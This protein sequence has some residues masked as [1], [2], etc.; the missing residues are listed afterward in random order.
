MRLFI[1]FEGK[2][3][4]H[5]E[6][7]SH[8]LYVDTK[9]M[10]T[11]F[12]FLVHVKRKYALREHYYLNLTLDHFFIADNESIKVLHDSDKL[13][14]RI[15]KMNVTPKCLRKNENIDSAEM[16]TVESCVTQAES[17][18]DGTVEAVSK[19]K[20]TDVHMSDENSE[21]K[22]KETRKSSPLKHKILQSAVCKKPVSMQ[23]AK[24][25]VDLF[26]PRKFQLKP[27]TPRAKINLGSLAVSSSSLNSRK[28]RI[29]NS[30]AYQDS[31]HSYKKNVDIEKS[32][33]SKYGFRSLD[34]QNQRFVKAVE[35]DDL[36][37]TDDAT[38]KT[39][40]KPAIQKTRQV[41][42]GH[43]K[44]DSESDENDEVMQTSSIV[45]YSPIVKP[46]YVEPPPLENSKFMEPSEGRGGLASLKSSSV[47]ANERRG[48]MV[49]KI[50]DAYNKK[51][52]SILEE[53][54]TQGSGSESDDE[55][56]DESTSSEDEALPKN[57]KNVGRFRRPDKSDAPMKNLEDASKKPDSKTQTPKDSDEGTNT[58]LVSEP[59][60]S[61][62]TTSIPN[63]QSSGP[64]KSALMGC[65]IKPTPGL[66]I[67]SVVSQL[68]RELEDS[69]DGSVENQKELQE[70]NVGVTEKK[71]IGDREVEVKAIEG[72][73]NIGDRGQNNSA[74]P[75]ESLENLLR[76]SS[77]HIAKNQAQQ[78]SLIGN[79]SDQIPNPT[80][81]PESRN[82]RKADA[83]SDTQHHAKA[84]PN[85]SVNE[86]TSEDGRKKQRF[87]ISDDE[88]D[89]S[90]EEVKEVEKPVDSSFSN[91][92]PDS[93]EN[94]SVREVK[95]SI[96]S[97]S[98]KGSGNLMNGDLSSKK[99]FEVH[100]KSS[101]A[102]TLTPIKP[103]SST[104]VPTQNGL[105]SD[106]SK[107]VPEKQRSGPP[108]LNSV[109]VNSK[110]S[111]SSSEETSEDE[112]AIKACVRRTSCPTAQPFGAV[113]SPKVSSTS[114]VAAKDTAPN[115]PKAKPTQNWCEKASIC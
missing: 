29:E 65:K 24:S 42:K 52:D 39:I 92:Q 108:S 23:P 10:F 11:V 40:D 81:D 25:S 103:G 56:D 47:E 84:M 109:F 74:E 37:N 64:T 71:L 75:E 22:I 12:D 32:K 51:M 19:S 49:D 79:H 5:L 111:S 20:P 99:R 102:E 70:Q 107:K 28:D 112:A 115:Y 105:K 100:S 35:S 62:K 60:K 77:E 101:V 3:S 16:E 96:A 6:H 86:Q 1:T 87:D 41:K 68:N 30:V 67:F 95:F 82:K 13:T 53:L 59:N 50:L 104:Y 69:K 90:V 114:S 34:Y 18:I 76:R 26:L 80:T 61:Q 66:N 48:A 15:S 85:G 36:V 4:R 57:E 94:Q 44:F 106:V 55:A 33:P 54:G 21:Q 88:N 17:Q 73:E 72:E 46:V 2:K 63:E 91:G 89:E 93:T 14:V 31:S 97:S 7:L 8:C 38:P 45:D 98:S 9:K 113:W 110:D 78:K 58:V 83:D 43:I 27:V